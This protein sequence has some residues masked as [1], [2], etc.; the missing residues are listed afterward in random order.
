M[1]RALLARPFD[2]CPAVKNGTAQIPEKKR[3]D[4]KELETAF[5]AEAPRYW[6]P[7]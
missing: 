5:K 1:N 7:Y 3:R 2:F 6:A 4:E